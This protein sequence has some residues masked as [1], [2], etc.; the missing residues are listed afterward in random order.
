MD[1]AVPTPGIVPAIPDAASN[2][3]PLK[4]PFISRCPANNSPAPNPT[5]GIF[6]S[7]P[8]P[9]AFAPTFAIALPPTLAPIFFIPFFSNDFPA[10]ETPLTNP[11]PC[12]ATLLRPFPAFLP[13]TLNFLNAFP[14]F[15]FPFER[16]FF[17]FL[18]GLL[19]R[20]FLN[21]FLNFLNFQTNQLLKK[22]N[23]H[24]SHQQ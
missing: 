2:I 12:L 22:S 20:N 16:N 13:T 19:L 18:N 11:F 1:T 21:L 10:L 14:T 7:N 5:N 23:D 17:A 15:P 3:A 6:L 8:F 9:S 24:D 4:S